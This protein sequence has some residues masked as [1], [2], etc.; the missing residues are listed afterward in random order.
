MATKSEIAD[1]EKNLTKGQLRKLKALRKSVGPAIGERAFVKWLKKANPKGD[2]NADLI[3]EA[4]LAFCDAMALYGR[5]SAEALVA[6]RLWKEQCRLVANRIWQ[7]QQR[8]EQG[9]KPPLHR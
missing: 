1:I 8:A 2:R 3:V 5:D 6:E 4:K 9:S 7:E